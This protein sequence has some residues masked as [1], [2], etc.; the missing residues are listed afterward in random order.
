[1]NRPIHQKSRIFAESI[2]KQPPAT[3][4]AAELKAIGKPYWL[5]PF[6]NVTHFIDV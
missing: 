5:M 6:I 1:M 2:P 3:V 4:P